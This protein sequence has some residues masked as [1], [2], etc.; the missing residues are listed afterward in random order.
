LLYNFTGSPGGNQPEAG[1]LLNAD[2]FYGT[3]YSGG[4]NTTYGTVYKIN[5][6]G[7]G[8]VTLKSFTNSPPDG[9][10]PQTPLIL[11]SNTFWGTTY[12]GG[13]A[14]G[15][16]GGGIVFSLQFPNPVIAWSF[17]NLA[18]TAGTNC[19]A[20]MPNVTGTNYI[21]ASSSAGP[22]TIT[23]SPTNNALLPA[24]TNLVV[25]AVTDVFTNTVYSTNQIVVQDQA[26]PIIALNGSNPFYV[27]INHAFT[28]PGAT[29][30]KSCGGA[31]PVTV[32]GTVTTNVLGTNI[33]T[34]TAVDIYGNT[35]TATRTVI[36]EDP[37][38]PT[39]NSIK[40]NPD[41]SISL[42]L[43][44]TP[45]SS[46]HVWTSTNLLLPMVSWQLIS[47]NVV[48]TNGVWDFLDTNNTQERARFYRASAP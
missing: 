2:T 43:T 37:S 44:N 14:S 39:I 26:P 21:L 19:E 9:G 35:N 40:L 38:P 23:Q 7:T 5:T 29:A 46:V 28:D 12:Y 32:S 4:S 33:L 30:V 13:N 45:G 22:V 24:G 27:E 1:L 6:N 11:N 8:Y 41:G 20:V 42:E 3:T 10:N 15:G 36:V 18:L 16:S 25:I 17:T 34:Y 48:G 47:S 31:V